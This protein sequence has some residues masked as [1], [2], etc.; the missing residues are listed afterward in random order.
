MRKTKSRKYFTNLELAELALERA[1]D[2]QQWKALAEMYLD[3][4]APSIYCKSEPTEV[5]KMSFDVVG[6]ANFG[7]N[8]GIYA[9]VILRSIDMML[10]LHTL[11]SLS[12][13]RDAYMA[14][15]QMA[16]IL[17][18]FVWEIVNENPNRFD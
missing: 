7:E 11:K 17:A 15:Q 14:M 13:D 4:A 3:Y 6:Y 2:D 9:S 12:T 5:K 10:P 16:G 1:K 8:E 18:Y